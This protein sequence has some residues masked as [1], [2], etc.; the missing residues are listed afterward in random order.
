MF[1]QVRPRSTLQSAISILELI[2]HTAVRNV[3]KG[4]G[5]AF[6]ALAS[7]LF[8]AVVFVGAFYLM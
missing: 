3:R 5:N 7:N 1:E 2:Y 4:H 8:T 6:M